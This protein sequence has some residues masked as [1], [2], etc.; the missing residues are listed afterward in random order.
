MEKFLDYSGLPGGKLCCFFNSVRTFKTTLLNMSQVN[1]MLLLN[2]NSKNFP[3]I[4]LGSITLQRSL[5]M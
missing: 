3:L 5:S 1:N 2:E 4:T